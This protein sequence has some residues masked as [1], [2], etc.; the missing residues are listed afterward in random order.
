M[1]HNDW[2]KPVT[3]K[4]KTRFSKAVKPLL[5][6]LTSLCL[7]RTRWGEG[8]GILLAHP[9]A[10]FA[11]QTKRYFLHLGGCRGQQG[12][13][14][15]AIYLWTYKLYTWGI[16]A[17]KSVN[18]FMYADTH[19]LCP[20][21][22][23]TGAQFSSFGCGFCVLQTTNFFTVNWMKH[24]HIRCFILWNVYEINHDTFCIT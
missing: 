15:Q 23:L 8:E 20:H 7:V 6:F 10:K 21:P 3:F 22:F 24:L 5:S 1:I 14:W 9:V 16:Y 18:V 17:D 19:C 13:V 2:F 12:F 4:S 11:A